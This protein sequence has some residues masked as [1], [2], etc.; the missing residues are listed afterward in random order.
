MG[1]AVGV[2]VL[3]G[4]AVGVGVSVGEGVA[5]AVAVAVKVAVGV[6]VSVCQAISGKRCSASSWQPAK[7]NISPNGM[8][9]VNCR[10]IGGYY[11]MRLGKGKS[12]IRD[13]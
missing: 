12:V 9:K 13:A 10:H 8:A 5:V 11:A 3:V 4:V 1:V 2:G 7:I 6:G